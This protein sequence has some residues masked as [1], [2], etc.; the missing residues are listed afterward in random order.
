LL[1]GRGADVILSIDPGKKPGCVVLSTEG[2]L[3]RASHKIEAWALC[4]LNEEDGS[5]KWP[6]A[7]TEGQWMY[8]GS[9]VDPNDLFTLAFRAGFTLASIPATRR[10]RI[11]VKVWRGTNATK[12]QVQARILRTLSPE[13]RECFRGIPKTRH[14]DVLDAIGI[15]R[16]ALRLAP[17]T[18]QYDWTLE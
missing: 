12:E 17:T 14:G 9:K 4:P 16:A 7:C 18:T 13:E 1:A 3:L 10:L 6:L 5:E 11:P 8:H 15:G 2:K